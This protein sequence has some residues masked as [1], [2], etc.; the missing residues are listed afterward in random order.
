MFDSP[1]ELLEKIQLREDTYLE[2]KEVR[3][4]GQRVND[5]HRNSCAD[6]IAAFANTRGGVFILGVDD[7]S[8]DVVG[9]PIDRI[10]LVTNFI[11][12]VCKDS[13]VPPLETFIV[14]HLRLPSYTGEELAVV[15][16]DVPQSLFVHRSPSGYLHR[17]GNAK[18]AMSTE[19]FAR[20]LQ[21]RSQ[22]RLI[23]FDEQTVQGATLADLE[24]E[25]IERFRI[26]G[27]QD[28]Q[29]TLARK[30][31]MAKKLDSGELR[32]TVTGVLLGANQPT[33]W[34]PHAYIQAVAYRGKSIPEAMESEWYQLDAS[35]LEGPLDR[36][37]FSACQFVARNQK[38]RAK[39][40]TGR[41]DQ[42][43]YDL[44]AVFEAVVNA[45]AHRD[46]SMHGSRI[47]LHMFSDRIELYSPGALSN[48]M[49]VDDLAYRQS[50]RNETL[51]SLL[52]RCRIP[53]GIL[54][55]DTPRTSIMDRR[56]NG[57]PIILSKSEKVSHK[58]PIYDVLGDAELRLTIYAAEHVND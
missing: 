2:V 28:D 21:Q 42:P 48:T 25:L 54:G 26:D 41:M 38:V 56:G 3:F 17:A 18:R 55:L 32:P 13:L 27:A 49:T 52:A 11:C 43:Q 10:E 35:D 5:P 6:T 46:Y 57:V 9:I 37:V 29:Q 36:L 8:F 40:E 20:L 51:T 7:K 31:G 16:V 50:S 1:V 53:E 58:R 30:L 19:Y 22:T 14:E 39:K 33:R 44:T 23:R 12:E 4:A 34:L 15:K 45:V 24:A 47:R